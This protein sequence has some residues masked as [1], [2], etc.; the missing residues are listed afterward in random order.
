MMMDDLEDLTTWQAMG[1]PELSERKPEELFNADFAERYRQLH[2]ILYERVIRL[3]GTIHTLEQLEEFPF[4]YIYGPRDNEFWRLV[5]ENFFDAACLKLHGLATDRGSAVHNVVSFKN[6]VI[7]GPWRDTRLHTLLKG[8]L[9][10]RKFDERA[11]SVATR[12]EAIRHT[13]IAHFLIDTNANDSLPHLEGV[14]LREVR[15]LFDAV[16]SLFGALSF[17]A[18]FV[19]LPGDLMPSTVGGKPTRTCLDT[20]LD[21]VLRDSP[22]VTRP[23]RNGEFWSHIRKHI[24]QQRLDVMNTLRRRVGLSEA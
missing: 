6:K 3:H 9:R 16:H 13:H 14:S 24:P 20:V 8:T 10:E 2:R 21:A 12:I 7:M 1:H 5:F 11:Q 22:F 17:G 4:G 18:A 19:T 15:H 23:E